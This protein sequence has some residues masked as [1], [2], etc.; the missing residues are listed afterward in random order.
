MSVNEAIKWL[1]HWRHFSTIDDKELGD[2][3]AMLRGAKEIIGD[4][5][6]PNAQWRERAE[7]W[8]KHWKANLCIEL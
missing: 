8:L 7:R 3:A 4:A 1:E 6:V 5:V 2:I